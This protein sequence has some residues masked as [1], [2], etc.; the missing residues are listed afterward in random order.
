[1]INLWPVFARS[2]TY[3]VSGAEVARDW[4]VGGEIDLILSLRN[5]GMTMIGPLLLCS[6]ECF[7]G[8]LIGDQ[9]VD[10]ATS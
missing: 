5:A 7:G 3:S 9:D 6:G 4:W 8:A 2:G 10:Q 1:M